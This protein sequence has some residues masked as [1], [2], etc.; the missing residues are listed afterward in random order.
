MHSLN[1]A[2]VTVVIADT[3]TFKDVASNH[4]QNRHVSISCQELV[5]KL[6]KR[7]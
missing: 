4:M 3:N 5:Q 1:S 6:L 2:H 7:G